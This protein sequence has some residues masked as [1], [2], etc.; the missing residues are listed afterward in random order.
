LINQKDGRG[1]ERIL[2]GNF[3]VVSM[4]DN[5]YIVTNGFQSFPLEEG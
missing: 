4:D 2:A 3:Y 5:G 1:K